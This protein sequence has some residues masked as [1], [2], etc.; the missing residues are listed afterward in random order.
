MNIVETIEM[1]AAQI[2]YYRKC[3]ENLN[4]CLNETDV[5][6]FQVEDDPKSGIIGHPK[7]DFTQALTEPDAKGLLINAWKHQINKRKEEIK[8]LSEKL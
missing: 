5:K 4:R 1:K 7:L 8:E 3:I 6:I 2:R